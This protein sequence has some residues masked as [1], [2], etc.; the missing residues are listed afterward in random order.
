M[1][2]TIGAS[3]ERVLAASDSCMYP[4]LWVAFDELFELAFQSKVAARITG[5]WAFELQ[6][7]TVDSSP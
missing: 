4:D 7:L 1:S 2:L 3:H 6:D 5:G